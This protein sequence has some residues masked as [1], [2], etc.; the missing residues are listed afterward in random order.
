ML[1]QDGSKWVDQWR[2]HKQAASIAVL[3]HKLLFKA[4]FFLAVEVRLLCNRSCNYRV[5]A[6]I[7]NFNTN[8]QK[9]ASTSNEPTS[10][11]GLVGHLDCGNNYD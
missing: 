9:I 5:K 7:F 4:A 2:P 6:R 1:L 3:Y 10:H 11:D 8:R